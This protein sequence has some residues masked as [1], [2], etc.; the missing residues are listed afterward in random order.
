V[1]ELARYAHDPCAFIDDFI[2]YNEKGQPWRLS[3][4]QRRV[5]AFAFRWDALGCLL[6]RLLLW[7]ELKKSGKS[8]LAACLTLWWAFV[9][10]DTE[11]IVSANDLEQ[12]V[13]RVF[14]TTAALCRHNSA[15]AASVIVRAAEILVSNGTIISAIASDYKGAA[16]SRHSLYVIDEPWGITEERAVRLVEELT[17]PPTEPNA[18]GLMTTTAGWIG[19]STLLEGLYERGLTGE[20]LDPELEVYRDHEMV[21]FWSHTPRQPWQTTEYYAQQRRSLRP[22]TYQR[23]HENQWISAESIFLTREL[24][25][26]CVDPEAR[27]VLSDLMLP[28]WLGLDAAVKHDSTGLVGVTYDFAT[29]RVRLVTHRIW[30][31]E[32]MVLDLRATAG[33]TLREYRERFD[34]RAVVY[35]PYQLA[36]L[37]AELTQDGLPMVEFP[38]TLDRLTAV[39]QNLLDL[40]TG[41]NLVLYPSDELEDQA[42]NTVAVESARGWRIAKATSSRKVDAIVA[43]GMAAHRCIADAAVPPVHLWGGPRV[44]TAAEIE[45]EERERDDIAREASQR[46]VAAMVRG[47]WGAR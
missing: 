38:Q 40:L 27:P 1:S 45:A 42:L 8:F 43:L 13:G 23:L 30:R 26:G 10:P 37:A 47:E 9:T 31:P 22:A 4:Y 29:K 46:A 28:V 14:R 36:V 16:G 11:I 44:R 6:M 2:P 7:S 19:E 35:D 24:W 41:Q 25:R 21:M 33:A 20:R 3:P 15:L 18:W 17:P 32:G 39:G 12:A 34:I 5:L